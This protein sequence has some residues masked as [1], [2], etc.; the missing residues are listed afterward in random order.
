VD[1]MIVKHARCRSLWPG[2]VTTASYERVGT[3]SN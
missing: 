2:S 3:R 1:G